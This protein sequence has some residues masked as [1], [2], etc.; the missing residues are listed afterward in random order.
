LIGTRRRTERHSSRTA[1]ERPEN[2]WPCHKH[3]H[4]GRRRVLACSTLWLERQSERG[5]SLS[6]KLR[7]KMFILMVSDVDFISRRGEEFAFLTPGE[8][9]SLNRTKM[10]QKPTPIYGNLILGH[11]LAAAYWN[12]PFLDYLSPLCKIYSRRTRKVTL[13]PLPKTSTHGYIQNCPRN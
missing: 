5:A 6:G 10:P 12:F 9:D 1:E 4:T 13:R 7:H 3:T 8:S 11:Y 2:S